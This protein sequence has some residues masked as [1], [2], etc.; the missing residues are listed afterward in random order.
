[1]SE[2]YL[3]VG[4]DYINFSDNEKVF[5]LSVFYEQL[6]KSKTWLS[7]G[8][9]VL[10]GQGINCQDVAALRNVLK[11]R[12]CQLEGFSENPVATEITH[13]CSDDHLLIAN[14]Q[15]LDDQKYQFSVLVNDKCD[16][17]CDHVTG[18]HVSGMIMMEA[19]R[20]A[21][22]A[23]LELSFGKSSDVNYSIMLDK[24]ET[25]FYGFMFPISALLTV[26]A[27]RDEN[28]EVNKFGVATNVTISQCDKLICT[29]K[30]S[31]KMLKK[32][33][34]KKLEGRGAVHSLKHLAV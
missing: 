2:R 27:S 25:D 9:Q 12:G 16:R 18:C 30:L 23:A 21:S 26:S 33:L 24:F 32:Q 10:L 1:M 6:A 14:L 34:F 31:G 8:E 13:K 28:S 22:I 3:V 17:L 29:L 20:Q 5:T 19:A 4:N 15:K 11:S 7:R